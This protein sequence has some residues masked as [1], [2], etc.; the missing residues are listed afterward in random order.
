MIAL[1]TATPSAPALDRE[2]GVAGV[3]AADRDQRQ[4]R[5]P[6]HRREPCG[7]DRAA[8]IGLG[9]GGG[10]GAVG[11]VVDERG[12]DRGDLVDR[13]ERD[14]EDRIGAE[15]R[16]RRRGRQVALAD[17]AAGG[18]RRHGDVDPVVDD[19]RDAQRREQGGERPG[20]LQQ[21]AAAGRLV[22]QLHQRDAALDRL[23]DDLA[24]R[25]AA[26]ERRVG[27]QIERRIEGPARH[28]IRTPWPTV[29]SSSA[30]S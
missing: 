3:D 23:G 28:A 27:H 25:A 4:R 13:V 9:G 7:A 14:A 20:L 29:A 22:A 18:A 21:R 6:P 8:G 30:A 12:I 26:A 2:P 5:A 11:D 17:V 19:Q 24:E 16:A 1:T 15:Q 10:E